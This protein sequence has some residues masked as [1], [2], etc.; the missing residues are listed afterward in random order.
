MVYRFYM[1][2]FIWTHSNNV[3]SYTIKTTQGKNVNRHTKK[4]FNFSLFLFSKLQMKLKAKFSV[5]LTENELRIFISFDR[6]LN[7]K[8]LFVENFPP[9]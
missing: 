4:S 6:K 5:F 7:G 2:F 3:F 1:Y 9:T 8:P